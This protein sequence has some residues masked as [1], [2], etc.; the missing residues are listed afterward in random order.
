MPTPLALTDAQSA[1]LMR[2]ARPL[3]P[4]DRNAFLRIVAYQLRDRLDGVGDGELHR[5]AAE[6]IKSNRLFDPP[7]TT[8]DRPAAIL[9]P[10]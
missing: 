3:Q 2:L 10:D 1:E 8:E 4:R 6:V 5:L 7:L 9:H